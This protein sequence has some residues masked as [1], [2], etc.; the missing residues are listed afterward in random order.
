[1]EPVDALVDWADVVIGP[2][3]SGDCITILCGST[4]GFSRKIHRN[5]PYD[6]K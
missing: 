6:K 1:M 3:K 4:H 2:Y 5:C